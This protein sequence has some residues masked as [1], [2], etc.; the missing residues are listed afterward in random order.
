M[1]FKERHIPVTENSKQSLGYLGT[2]TKLA[3]NYQFG[4]FVG[5]DVCQMKENFPCWGVDCTGDVATTVLESM[6]DINYCWRLF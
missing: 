3:G 1:P 2:W 4:I 5:R 6:A